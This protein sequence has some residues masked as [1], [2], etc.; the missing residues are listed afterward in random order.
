MSYEGW[1]WPM[2]RHPTDGALPV[3]SDG[4][5]RTSRGGNGH[6]GVDIMYRRATSG[7]PRLP[8]Y[9]KGFYCP[10][11]TIQ[12]YAAGP[13]KVIAVH[14]SDPHGISLEI[15]HHLVPDTGPRVTAYR[16]LSVCTVLAG[17]NVAAG[18][19]LGLVGYDRTRKP[20]ETPNHL[21]FELWDTSRVQFS[22][23]DQRRKK[24]GIDP[25]PFMK[26]WVVRDRHGGD[27]APAPDTG[28]REQT[29]EGDEFIDDS[30]LSGLLVASIAAKV[31]FF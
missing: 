1:V 25:A 6:F 22:G 16:H 3:I 17:Q 21:H 9:T 5:S 20:T 8:D 13:G 23:Q 12:A 10:S 29:P 19:P 24:Y 14:H 30:S 15:D 4:F 26:G 28:A 2:E 7:T 11:T 18:Q 31:L 27:R